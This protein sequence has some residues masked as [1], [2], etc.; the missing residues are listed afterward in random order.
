MESRGFLFGAPLAL[1][2]GCA[3][4]PARKPGKLPYDSIGVDYGLEYG[5]DRLEMHTD[6][7]TAGQRVL[8]MDDLLAT[9]G[10]AGATCSLIDQLGG[11]VVACCFVVELG[12]LPGREKIGEIAVESIVNYG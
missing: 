9:G 7:I 11:K 5:K 2:L 10:T 8:V 4:V 12:F 1:R 6:A 3:F